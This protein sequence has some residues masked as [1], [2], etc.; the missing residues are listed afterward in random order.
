MSAPTPTDD[1]PV[2]RLDRILSFTA[3]GLLVLSVGCF[4]AIMIGSAMHA[5]FDRGAWPTVGIAVYVGP[6]VAFLLIIAVVIMSMVRR[7]RANRAR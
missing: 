3:L 5:E 7:A 2:R 1:V 4:V 6:I